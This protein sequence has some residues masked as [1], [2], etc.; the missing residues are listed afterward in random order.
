MDSQCLR[1]KGAQGK[2]EKGHISQDL[3][4]YYKDI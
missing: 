3:V 1:V 2:L 4:D